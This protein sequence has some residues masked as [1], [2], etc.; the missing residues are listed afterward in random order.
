[1]WI[2]TVFKNKMLWENMSREKQNLKLKS[3]F[4]FSTILLF[5]NFEY[6]LLKWRVIA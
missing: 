3:S 4:F 2:K 5:W 6:W 1:M